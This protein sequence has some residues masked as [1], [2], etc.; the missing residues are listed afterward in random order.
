MGRLWNGQIEE[1]RARGR[2]GKVDLKILK[3][4][5]KKKTKQNKKLLLP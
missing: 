3:P 2:K 1:E 4:R 5:G